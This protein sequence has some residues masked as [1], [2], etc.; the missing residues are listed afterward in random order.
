MI[1]DAPDAVRGEFV[2]T[3]D[4]CWPALYRALRPETV[5]DL[6]TWMGDV[7]LDDGTLVHVYR[8]IETRT[9]LHLT[10]DARALVYTGGGDQYRFVP[11]EHATVNAFA[12]RQHPVVPI[13][14]DAGCAALDALFDLCTEVSDELGIDPPVRDAVVPVPDR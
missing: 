13:E 4:P 12:P 9:F 1:S 6:F 11:I 10:D 7:R 3:D 5:A 2:D 14:G 8:Q